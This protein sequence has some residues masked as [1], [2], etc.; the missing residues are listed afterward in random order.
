[1]TSASISALAGRNWWTGT[2]PPRPRS[3]RS[4]LPRKP[5]CIVTLIGSIATR[6]GHA[7]QHDDS[8]R[9]IPFS[10]PSAG[11]RREQ[12]W[13]PALCLG[14]DTSAP[15]GTIDYLER[16]RSGEIVA[17]GRCVFSGILLD[18]DPEPWY[19]SIGAG[20]KRTSTPLEFDHVTISEV[21]LTRS[22]A[23]IGLRP[24]Q[25]A[26]GVDLAREG[27]CQPAGLPLLYRGAWDRAHE[28][29][30]ARRRRRAPEHLLVVGIDPPPAPVARRAAVAAP[31]KAAKGPEVV[32]VNGRQL[33]PEASARFLDLAEGI[34]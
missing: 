20:V 28:V 3:A 5:D 1:M 6:D 15:V 30:S 34:G 21:S 8:G 24:V 11:F 7:L 32:Y 19:F 13:R 22:P 33:S 17:V 12:P 29:M 4:D 14:H 2:L 9:A 25:W 27:G 26:S 18:R 23:G 10:L 31:Q 16:L